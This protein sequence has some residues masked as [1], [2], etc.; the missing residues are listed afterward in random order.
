MRRFDARLNYLFGFPLHQNDEWL[1]QLLILFDVLVRLHYNFFDF[2]LDLEV[3]DELSSF[4]KLTDGRDA[5]A[6]LLD[7][8]LTDG[9][10][11]ARALFVSL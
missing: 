3:K 9:Q 4:A 5:T 10:S 6:H 1:E 2:A 8:L 7:D 11:K